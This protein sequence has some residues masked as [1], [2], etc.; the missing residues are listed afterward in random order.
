MK[1]IHVTDKMPPSDTRVLILLDDKIIEIGMC[2][3]KNDW[4]YDSGHHVVCLVTHWMNLPKIPK[5]I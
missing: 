2:D 3:W 5:I 4:I 1:W